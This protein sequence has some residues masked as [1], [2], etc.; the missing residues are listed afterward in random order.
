MGRMIDG[1]RGPWWVVCGVWWVMGWRGRRGRR[2]RRGEREE[3]GE[4]GEGRREEEE[5]EEKEERWDWNGA[6]GSGWCLRVI[7]VLG[8]HKTDWTVRTKSMYCVTYMCLWC[9]YVRTALYLPYWRPHTTK[10]QDTHITHITHPCHPPKSTSLLLLY[11]GY[12]MWVRGGD[13]R[14]DNLTSPD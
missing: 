1:F 3:K 4:E 10:Y 12:G 8:T 13:D 5:E 11:G 7:G 9:L 6:V 14:L 2:R